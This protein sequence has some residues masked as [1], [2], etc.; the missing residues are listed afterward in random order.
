[1]GS[2]H[3]IQK[4]DFMKRNLTVYDLTNPEI[5][6]MLTDIYQFLLFEGES[7]ESKSEMVD[8]N[9]NMLQ[10]DLIYRISKLQHVTAKKAIR[11]IMGLHKTKNSFTQTPRSTL[12]EDMK[13]LKAEMDNLY[14]DK[15][16]YRQDAENRK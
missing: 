5:E 14:R 15:I 4:P 13:D 8:E 1:M 7:P 6:Y 11:K 16:N 3:D 9:Y 12:E 10:K 2:L